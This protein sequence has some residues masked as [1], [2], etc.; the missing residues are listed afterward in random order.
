MYLLL[1]KKKLCQK[2]NALIKILFKLWCANEF[3]ALNSSKTIQYCCFF[4]CYKCCLLVLFFFSFFL[5]LFFVLFLFCFFA[6][7][8]LLLLWLLLLPLSMLVLLRLLL[9]LRL[10]LLFKFR[11]WAQ[12]HSITL[13]HFN[14]HTCFGNHNALEVSYEV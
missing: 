5:F 8:L 3:S 6:S 2:S 9:L 1:Y 13:V 4:C 12:D 14:N 7:F 10:M 11:I